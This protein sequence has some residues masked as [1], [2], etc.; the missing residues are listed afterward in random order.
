MDQRRKNAISDLSEGIEETNTN[1]IK[2]GWAP[3][4]N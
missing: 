2:N 3:P 4:R 1:T